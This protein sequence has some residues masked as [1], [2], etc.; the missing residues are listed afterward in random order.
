MVVLM[1]LTLMQG[2]SG[3]AKENI[4]LWIIS[5][6]KQAIKIKLA[7]KVG[8]DKFYFSL[9]PSVPEVSN[10][11]D[12]ISVSCKTY[13]WN[14]GSQCLHSERAFGVQ[15]KDVILLSCLRGHLDMTSNETMFPFH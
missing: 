4:Q 1:T 12:T 10:Y 11:S 6:T 9:N 8:H 7:A 2:H 13:V 15:T 3:S 5:T 14:L